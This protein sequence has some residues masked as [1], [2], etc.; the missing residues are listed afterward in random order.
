MHAKVFVTFDRKWAETSEAA[1]AY[2][3]TVLREKDCLNSGWCFVI[4]GTYSGELSSRPG[5]DAMVLTPALY[6]RFLRPH[7]GESKS[8]EH[9]D[10]DGN[11][12]SPAMIGH[13]W[14]VIVDCHI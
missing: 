5:D 4:G 11:P 1:R 12:V 7:E 8:H 13:T 6:E 2:V 10:L 9:I 14:L 3:S